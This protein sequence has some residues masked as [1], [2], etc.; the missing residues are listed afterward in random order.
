MLP[1]N[2]STNNI[3]EAADEAEGINPLKLFKESA[4]KTSEIRSRGRYTQILDSQKSVKDYMKFYL[5]LVL[6][7]IR[8]LRTFDGDT[9]GVTDLIHVGQPLDVGPLDRTP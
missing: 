6:V 9:L 5:H 1:N 7:A 2:D 8:E 3:L 4:V